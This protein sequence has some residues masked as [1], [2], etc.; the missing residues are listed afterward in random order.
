MGGERGVGRGIAESQSDFMADGRAVL[1]TREQAGNLLGPGGGE[2]FRR[3]TEHD[4]AAGVHE[5]GGLGGNFSLSVGEREEVRLFHCG[6]PFDDEGA[7]GGTRGLV[8]LRGHVAG[9]GFG[10]K[11]PLRFGE[12][13][14]LRARLRGGANGQPGADEVTAGDAALLALQP[15]HERG[16]LMRSDGR[17]RRDLQ[18]DEEHG[19]ILINVGDGFPGSAVDEFFRHGPLNFSRDNSGRQS[20]VQFRRFSRIA[21][22]APVSMPAGV[23]RQFDG[24]GD[25]VAG[26]GRFVRENEAGFGGTRASQPSGLHAWKIKLRPSHRDGEQPEQAESTHET[27]E[28]KMPHQAGVGK[29]F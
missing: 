25:G 21:A 1:L 22:V 4:V 23:H 6:I 24:G 7:I 14:G 13:I 12:E 16:Q 5:H 8:P 29:S 15:L 3:G 2:S 27:H 28:R 20:P 18:R 19:A 9:K 17:V 11:Q 10:G 26:L